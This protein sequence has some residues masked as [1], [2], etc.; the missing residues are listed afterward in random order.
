M[1]K[2]NTTMKK[3]TIS[4]LKTNTSSNSNNSNS[5]GSVETLRVLCRFRPPYKKHSSIAGAG[6]TTSTHSNPNNTKPIPPNVYS[7]PNDSTLC[8]KFD[9]YDSKQYTFDSVF[10][11]NSTQIDIF[12]KVYVYVY[13]V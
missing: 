5:N 12:N 4:P 10:N 7:F 8:I 1:I 11:S 6:A 13:I 3:K 2:N 9:E